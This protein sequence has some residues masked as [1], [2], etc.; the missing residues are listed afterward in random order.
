MYFGRDCVLDDLTYSHNS[1]CKL[2]LLLENYEDH[3]PFMSMTK[4][5]KNHAGQIMK[6]MF[7][8]RGQKKFEAIDAWFAGWSVSHSKGA[9]IA[10][11][12]E[13]ETF[14]QL[15]KLDE[16]EHLEIVVYQIEDD[17][18]SHNEEHRSA[19][20]AKL[21]GGPLSVQAGKACQEKAFHR[22]LEREFKVTVHDSKAAANVVRQY[23]E[24]SSRA[25]LDHN[26][27]AAG[28]WRSLYRGYLGT[29]A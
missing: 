9:T 3:E 12:I 22:Y 13:P 26:R 1:G 21:K 25:K 2:K 29:V 18:T 23:C 6:I 8:R 14:D 17:G 11:T 5:R 16:K 20:E 19:V 28:Q 15:R 7:R 4:R 27:K 24:V 10:A